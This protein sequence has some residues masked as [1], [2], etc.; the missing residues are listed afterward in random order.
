MELLKA[1]VLGYCMGVRRA[2]EMAYRE[3][4]AAPG[5]VY[6]MGSLIH[7]PQV[8]EDL[9]KRGAVV[10]DEENL[11][12]S[13]DGASVVIRAHGIGAGLE[14]E[15]VSR[16]ARITDATCPR[17]KASQLKARCLAE[18]G[19]RVFLA[20]E[21]RHREIVGIRGYAPGCI[22]VA[23][24]AEAAAAAETLFREEPAAR[25]A[26]LGQTTISPD[27]YA[28]IGEAVGAWF[29]RLEVVDTICGATRERQDALRELCGRVDAVIVAGGRESANTRRLIAIAEGM[30]KPVL[31][32]ESA[33]EIPPGLAAYDR[34]G[35]SAGASTP[36]A[37]IRDI[38]GSFGTGALP[39]HPA[40]GTCSPGPP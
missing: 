6:L 28:V 29:P 10:L 14:A 1:R 25:T 19:Y 39:P 15:L 21:E 38:E 11:P 17:V 3:L 16:G 20:G 31:P 26:L 2:V 4:D 37:V 30:G 22:V 12:A 18:S 35:L 34:V 32:V 24:G 27:E 23:D 13:L 33:S 36:D 8:M 7:N 40:G 5:R 9:K